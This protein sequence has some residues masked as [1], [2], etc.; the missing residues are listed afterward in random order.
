MDA[1]QIVLICVACASVLAVI[2]CGLAFA[3]VV[4]RAVFGTRQVK[5]ARFR[6]FTEE[7]FALKGEDFPVF[8]SGISLSGRLYFDGA[9]KDRDTLVIFVHG[10]GA[11]SSSYTTEI[12]SLVRRGYAVLAYDAYGCN[13]S[14]GKGI[15][16]FYCGA[17]CA[18]AAVL[19]ARRDERLKDKRTFLVG[20]S[21][22]AYSALCAAS[23]VG[24]DGVVAL[25]AFNDPVKALTDMVNS[26]MGRPN[27]VLA[28]LVYPWFRLINAIKFGLKGNVKA[29]KAVIESGTPALIIHGEHDLT[30]PI[31]NSAA[32]AATGRGPKVEVLAGKAH[33]PYNTP[34]AERLLG[35][36]LTARF[37]DEK[38]ERLY[39]DNF[40]WRAATEE[41]E[42]VMNEIYAFIEGKR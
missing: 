26:G 2:S 10:F 3:I 7:D 8:Y 28:A 25:S 40:D 38:E 13:A 17:E 22:G 19:A 16:G 34:D 39:F 14:Q 29:A 37:A 23:E 42:G 20:H 11:G 1:W 36:L 9:L 31:T 27:R 12:A 18:I 32:L 41:D 30:V 5:D 24:V 6:Y 35:M 33:N 4:D 15:R 21:W